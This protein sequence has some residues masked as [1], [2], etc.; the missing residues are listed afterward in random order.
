M[1]RCAYLTLRDSAIKIA[2]IG[3]VLG[4]ILGSVDAA[5]NLYRVS[6]GLTPPFPMFNI[7]DILLIILNFVAILCCLLIH[8]KFLPM[9]NEDPLFVALICFI[10]G[11]VITFGA[12]GIGGILIV[13]SGILILI[14][15]TS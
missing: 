2:K 12:L 14:Y 10:L 8:Q 6:S 1:K 11:I 15:E 13:I 3:V 4:V 9:V 7:F 5:W